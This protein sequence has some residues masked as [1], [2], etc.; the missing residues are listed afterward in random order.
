MRWGSRQKAQRKATRGLVAF[1]LAALCGGAAPAGAAIPDG[2]AAANSLTLPAGTRIEIAVVRP[3]PVHTTK[4]GD[5]LYGET[6][7]PVALGDRI[8]IPAGTWVQG[9]IEAVTPPSRRQAR[10][11]LDI[12]FTQIIFANSYVAALPDA[13]PGAPL[14]PDATEM[15]VAI[16]VSAANDLLL[17][18]G[19]QIE[20]ALG[21]P[22]TLDAEQVSG[23]LAQTHAPDPRSF[24]SATMCRPMPGSP[25]TPGTPDTVIPGTPGTPDTVIPGGPGMPDTVIPGTPATPDTVI[26]G[27]PDTP[28]IPS[29]VCPPP[30]IVLSSVPVVRTSA[31][32][33]TGTSPAPAAN[34]ST[35]APH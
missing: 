27:M 11:Q 34:A 6:N 3:V 12:L 22:L 10:A 19:A 28:G 4:A 35:V 18:N 5:T 13:A 21:A 29:T 15:R 7:Y 26:P 32:A 17:D 8:A 9:R 2:Q 14:P 24:R 33:G 23:A 1:L 16:Q 31:G 25:G 20:M 30:P